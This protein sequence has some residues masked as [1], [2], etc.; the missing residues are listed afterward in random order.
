MHR[1]INEWNGQCH[2]R[3]CWTMNEVVLLVVATK[4]QAMKIGWV[5]PTPNHS[6]MAP[7]HSL[8]ALSHPLIAQNHSLVAP[9]HVNSFTW[10]IRG[11]CQSRVGWLLLSVLKLLNDVALE[12]CSVN[13]R[14]DSFG[15]A[16][17]QLS[18]SSATSSSLD[19]IAGH[20]GSITRRRDYLLYKITIT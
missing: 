9:K 5:C 14:W 3:F 10:W 4:Q 2:I 17:R 20:V 11:T 8:V 7:N 16:V 6:L 19:A 12:S 18:G 15:S 1:R 13:L